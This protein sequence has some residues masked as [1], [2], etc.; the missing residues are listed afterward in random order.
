MPTM[1][2]K[3]EGMISG[4]VLTPGKCDTM[5]SDAIKVARVYLGMSS[6]ASNKL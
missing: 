4:G 5:S 1:G 2:C 6:F 3:I